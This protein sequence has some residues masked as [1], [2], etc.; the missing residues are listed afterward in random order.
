MTSFW[1]YLKSVI[2]NAKC[3]IIRKMPWLFFAARAVFSLGFCL[4]FIKPND[5]Y[6]LGIAIGSSVLLLL[7]ISLWVA[8]G[9]FLDRLQILK[10]KTVLSLRGFGERSIE[11]F[12]ASCLKAKEAFF[13]FSTLL[14][15]IVGAICIIIVVLMVCLLE[16]LPMKLREYRGRFRGWRE[17]NKVLHATIRLAV[18]SF[19]AY[20]VLEVVPPYEDPHG[21][22]T[23]RFFVEL[24]TWGEWG[25]G[26]IVRWFTLSGF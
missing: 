20:F 11:H 8:F 2:E 25:L 24:A 9:R 23:F 6:S 21:A 19:L 12:I 17:R 1:E 13:Y 16:G 5:L 3:S 10:K 18:I 15:I 7:V 14:E 22:F 4:F 26:R